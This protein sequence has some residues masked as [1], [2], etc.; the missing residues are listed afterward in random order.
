MHTRDT[1]PSS[2][3]SWKQNLVT[4]WIAELIAIVGFSVVIPLLPLYISELGVQSERSVRLWSGAIF[5]AHAVSM[6][7]FAPLW[8]ALSDRYGRKV[9]VERAMFA[10]AVIIVLM[11]LAQNVQQ[12]VIL[13]VLQ[14]ALTGTVTAANALVATNTPK[15]HLGYALGMLQMAIYVGASAGPLLGGLVA[16]TVGYRAAF[17]TTGG[18]LFIAALGVLFFV[19]ESFTPTVSRSSQSSSS[20]ST[21]GWQEVRRRV[22]ERFS[23]FLQNSALRNVMTI[24]LLMR[25]GA[26]LL[27]PVLPLFIAAIALPG[28]R[29]ASTT[30]FISGASSLAG[31]VGALVMGRLGDRIGYRS[32]LVACAFLSVACYA[33][34]ALVH[35]PRWLLP[36]QAGTGLAMGGILASLSASLAH[37]APEG[38]EGIVYGVD[39]TVVSIANAIG[40][41]AGS[42][43]AAWIGLRPPF[44]VA[45]AV[46][47]VAGLVAMQLLPRVSD[48]PQKGKG[49]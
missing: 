48:D 11:G 23:P 8:G 3:P 24:R 25:L 43:L 39:A 37:L 47:G 26:R 6:A 4:I 27:S 40:P 46:F 44:L 28:T 12:L 34:Q 33:P 15:R 36:F 45:A 20:R 22:R 9:M 41:M 17:W 1:L 38:R 16:D 7:I 29:I 18:L 32:I 49:E 13:R 31:A 10:G 19:R 21:R 42:A 14:G 35:D 5:S 30:G 2:S